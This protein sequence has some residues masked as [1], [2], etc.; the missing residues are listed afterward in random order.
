M[1]LLRWLLLCLISTGILAFASAG[2]PAPVATAKSTSLLGVKLG[3]HD[4]LW[5]RYLVVASLLKSSLAS[6]SRF[7]FTFP[8]RVEPSALLIPCLDT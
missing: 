6:A 2:S 3:R 4:L 5:G 7:L 1:S 8:I